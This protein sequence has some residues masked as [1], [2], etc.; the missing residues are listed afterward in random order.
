MG[1]PLPAFDVSAALLPFVAIAVPMVAVTVLVLGLTRSRDG[2]PPLVT[3]MLLAVLVIGGGSVLLLALLFVFLNPN[4][5]TA[6]EWVLLAFNFMMMVP[7]GLWFISHIIFRDRRVEP[8]SWLWPA[9]LGVAVTGSEMLM[10]LLFAVGGASGAIGATVAFTTGLSSVWFFWSMA[11]VMAPLVVWAPLSSVGRA[12]GWSLVGAAVLAPWVR[13]YPSVGGGAM[14]V[15]MAVV[16]TAW[17]R[18]LLRGAVSHEDGPLLLA[19]AASFLAM[20]ATGLGVAVSGGSPAAV[21]AFGS[22]MAVVMVAEV[23]YLIRRSYGSVVGLT[24]SPPPLLTSASP[25]GG[26]TP[27]S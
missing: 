23:S 13:S 16:F 5:A 24:T 9:G 26:P 10:G 27:R 14:A 15:L 3:Q 21:L 11:A 12:G 6:W 7:L 1:L 22:T 19:L 20:T 25:R 17:L 18:P 2:R 8:A 4:G